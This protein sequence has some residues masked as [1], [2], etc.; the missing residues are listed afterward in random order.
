MTHR[1]PDDVPALPYE[2]AYRHS[3]VN[4]PLGTRS[5]RAARS[6]NSSLPGLASMGTEA[7][8]EHASH[9]SELRSCRSPRASKESQEGNLADIWVA[10]QLVLKSLVDLLLVADDVVED[11]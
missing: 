8:V 7:L 11:R 3:T 2:K 9:G 4:S 5:D 6:R 1:R 10:L